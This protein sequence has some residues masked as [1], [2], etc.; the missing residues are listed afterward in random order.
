MSET[1]DLEVKNDIIRQVKAVRNALKDALDK[2]N[3]L[4][5]TEIQ[6]FQVDEKNNSNDFFNNVSSNL[7]DSYDKIVNDIL[8]WLDN[9]L[10]EMYDSI[11]SNK[12]MISNKTTGY[13]SARKK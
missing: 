11:K 8:P 3:A 6:S 4:S 10:N 1:D 5:S 12:H 13:L 7:K 2:A 9:D